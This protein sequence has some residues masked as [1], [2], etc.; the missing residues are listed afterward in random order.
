M[1]V[2][3]QASFIFPWCYSSLLACKLTEKNAYLLAPSPQSVMRAPRSVLY[4]APVMDLALQHFIS[5][6]IL[7]LDSILYFVTQPSTYNTSDRYLFAWAYFYKKRSSLHTELSSFWTLYQLNCPAADSVHVLPYVL[8][9]TFKHKEASKFYFYFLLHFL[10][11]ITAQL[12]LELG[13]AKK[14][15]LVHCILHF[16]TWTPYNNLKTVTSPI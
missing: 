6:H 11:M 16:N 14:M 2:C 9:M 12:L 7:T 5:K 10:I 13:P 15:Q 8:K 4:S 1:N 3:S